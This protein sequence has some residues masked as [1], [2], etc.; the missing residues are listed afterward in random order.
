MDRAPL[1]EAAYIMQPRAIYVC[2][3]TTTQGHTYVFL[4]RVGMPV[5][6]VRAPLPT[7]AVM[8]ATGRPPGK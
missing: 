3:S 5:C 4:S 2:T 8:P 1:T 6:D 7:M